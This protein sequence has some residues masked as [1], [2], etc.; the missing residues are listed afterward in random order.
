MQDNGSKVK[1]S[2][3]FVFDFMSLFANVYFGK[4]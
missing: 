3:T 2:G 1:Y 4:T